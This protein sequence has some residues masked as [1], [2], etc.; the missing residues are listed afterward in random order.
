VPPSTQEVKLAS[1]TGS[2][3]VKADEANGRRTRVLSVGPKDS[4]FECAFDYRVTYFVASLQDWLKWENARKTEMVA[5]LE[6][7]SREPLFSVVDI[8]LQ[9]LQRRTKFVDA[10]FPPTESSLFL[11]PDNTPSQLRIPI[12]WK[13]PSDFRLKGEPVLFAEPPSPNQ[14]AQNTPNESRARRTHTHKAHLTAYRTSRAS[15]CCS[16]S[17]PTRWRRTKREQSTHSQCTE[18]NTAEHH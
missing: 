12:Q 3:V 17:R 14:V 8:E 7:L 4:S 11:D 10:E 1:A 16:P 6:P 9:M 15:W 5:A 13:R 2:A 18:Y